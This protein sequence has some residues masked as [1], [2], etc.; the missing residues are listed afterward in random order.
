MK[1]AEDRLGCDD[2]KA[3]NRPVEWGILVQRAMNT[4][5]ITLRN[6]LAQD[7]AQLRL[8]KYASVIAGSGSYSTSIASAA[9]RAV[10]K[11]SVTTNATG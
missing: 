2:A 8:P 3:L 9:S 4:R 11:V 7:P 6:I 5:F 1:A 10:V